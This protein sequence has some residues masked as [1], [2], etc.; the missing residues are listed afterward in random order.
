M[1][2]PLTCLDHTGRTWTAL[3]E[4]A[5]GGEGVIAMVNEDSRLVAKLYHKPPSPQTASKLQLMVRLATPVLHRTTAWPWATLHEKP[6]GKLTGFLMP[7]FD[8]YQPIQHLYSPA[9]RKRHF[10]EADWP[11]LIQT[12][13]LCA[14]AFA[15]IHTLGCVVGD[16][17]QGNIL[18][19]ASGQVTLIDCDSFQVQAGGQLYLCEVG[20]PFFTPPE[21]QEEKSFRR[22][23]T[24]NHDRFGLAVLLFCLLMVGRH[25][26]MGRYPEAKEIELEELIRTYR[27]AYGR[28]ATRLQMEPPLGAPL[29]NLL[30][31]ELGGLFERAFA[32]GSETNNARP[33]PEE[34]S[35]ALDEFRSNLRGCSDDPGHHIPGHWKECPWCSIQACGGPSYFEGVA[36]GAVEF[37]P[38]NKRLRELQHDLER[39]SNHALDLTPPTPSS[40]AEP[41]PLPEE[42]VQELFQLR[43]LRW[44]AATAG[45]VCVTGLCITWYLAL[46]GLLAMLIFSCWATVVYLSSGYKEVL[47]HRQQA[48]RDADEDLQDIQHQFREK[49]RNVISEHNHLLG[50]ITRDSEQWK[51]LPKS[52]DDARRQLETNKEALARKAHLQSCLLTDHKIPGIGDKRIQTLILHGIETS[53]D[54][55]EEKILAI[56]G[57]GKVLAGHLLVW[58]LRM[59]EE[60]RFNAASEVSREERQKVA[61]YFQHQQANL[62]NQMQTALRNLELLIS[63]SSHDVH[64]LRRALELSLQNVSQAHV[65]WELAKSGS[66][67]LRASS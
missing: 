51:G 28:H 39:L 62:R 54:I 24:V 29:L 48:Y 55:T 35:I 67:S 41:S 2:F 27:F 59:R 50:M 4:I 38:D 11:F 10:P 3:R 44:V 8:G 57:F 53:W 26:F 49:T 9:Q 36:S 15:E 21:L 56:K 42:I 37:I 31:P 65:D 20:T 63:R 23:R 34:W 25:P 40:A 58:K 12:A 32:Q 1:V 16:V 22:L 19:S 45:V 13:G 66:S 43:L 6:G 60:F 7:R 17:N 64:D 33:R 46:F 5:S 47:L 52:Y 14:R 61:M 30:S 18:V